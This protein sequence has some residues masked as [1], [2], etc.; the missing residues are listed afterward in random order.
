[1]LS[2]SINT[3]GNNKNIPL[4]LL[5]DSIILFSTDNL[6]NVLDKIKKHISIIEKKI[7]SYNENLYIGIS[8]FFLHTKPIDDSEEYLPN[9]RIEGLE[10]RIKEYKISTTS[11]SLNEDIKKIDILKSFT[12]K[13]ISK[14]QYVLAKLEDVLSLYNES[15]KKFIKVIEC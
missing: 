2:I 13:Q 7:K 3:K 4:S 6:Y 9:M 11:K 5:E 15:E 14:S 12:E 1:M 10:D 8:L